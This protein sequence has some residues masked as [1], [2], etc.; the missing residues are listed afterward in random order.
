MSPDLTAVVLLTVEE[1][2]ELFRRPGNR[3]WVYDRA[4]RGFLKPYA[5]RFGRSLY[6]DRVGIERLISGLDA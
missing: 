1:V 6:F 4:D 5:R 2:A 3:K